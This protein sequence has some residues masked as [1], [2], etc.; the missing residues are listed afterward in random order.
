VQNVF[1]HGFSPLYKDIRRMSALLTLSFPLST[2]FGNA[3]PSTRCSRAPKP[4]MILDRTKNNRALHV[5]RAAGRGRFRDQPLNVVGQQISRDGDLAHL[6]G[7]I[8]AVADDFAPISMSF[9]F[10]LVSDQCLI[11]SGVA[12]NERLVQGMRLKTPRPLR[13]FPTS[14][15]Q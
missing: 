12:A 11:G 3:K 5:E 2:D 10:K 9:S 15:M 14:P 1:G 4:V 7:D 13:L 8:P 6:E